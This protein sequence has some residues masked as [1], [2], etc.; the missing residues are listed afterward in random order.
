MRFR[1]RNDSTFGNGPET[2]SVW[3]IC[4]PRSACGSHRVQ[5]NRASFGVLGVEQGSAACAP[6]FRAFSHGYVLQTPFPDNNS[7]VVTDTYPARADNWTVRLFSNGPGR[8]I[9]TFRA[10]CAP[11]TVDME[12][13]RSPI[14][15]QAATSVASATC[16]AGMNTIA[17]GYTLAED[18]RIS[19]AGSYPSR[20]NA[21][22]VQVRPSLTSRV[23]TDMGTV[24]ATCA[25]TR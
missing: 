14:L 21:W 12:I 1:G 22:T 10:F 3:A 23:G 16:P 25:R 5:L 19:V 20:P 24:Y 7:Y 2:V 4:F 9:L 13:V 6:G 8:K 17:G 18:I 15:Y 11:N